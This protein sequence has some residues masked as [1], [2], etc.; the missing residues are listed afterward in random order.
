MISETVFAGPQTAINSKATILNNIPLNV[1]RQKFQDPTDPIELGKVA[2]ANQNKA[3][4]NIEDAQSKGENA[5]V[6]SHSSGSSESDGTDIVKLDKLKDSPYLSSKRLVALFIGDLDER[7][8]E[9]M[10][11]DT[12][13]KYPS[14]VSVKICVDAISK[15]SLGYGY[16]NFSNDEDAGKATEE[17][18]YVPLF[19]KEV[20]IMPSLRNSF[21]RKNI[22]TNVFF[23]NLPL[24][25]LSLTTR[26]FYDT[27]K[28]Y[29]KILSCKLDR[30][31]NIGFIYFDKDTSAKS[32]IDDF[33]G[34]E[35]YGNNIM[36]GIHFDREVRKSPEFEKRKSKL[37]G[38][39]II[40]EKLLIDDEQELQEV[41][42]G[43]KAPHP[44]AIFV[45]NLPVNANEDDILDFF[46]RIGPVKS[47]F[48]SKVPK[49]NS[50]WAF[51]TYKK[52]S[53]TSEAIE[54]LNGEIFKHRKIEV[55]R[56]QKNFQHPSNNANS[57]ASD[58]DASS[59]KEYAA[60]TSDRSESFN[61][62]ANGYKLSVYL[63]NMS[64]IC[65]EEFL[66]YL[67]AQERIKT[68]KISVCLY[69]EKTLTY[70]G[71]VLCQTRNDANR[72]FEL[73]DQKLLGDSIVKASWQSKRSKMVSI[74]PNSRLDQ[75][76]V[77]SSHAYTSSVHQYQSNNLRNNKVHFSQPPV[78]RAA[79]CKSTLSAI[80]FSSNRAVFPPHKNDQKYTARRQLLQ[81]VKQQVGRCIDFLKFP[82]A[83]RDE[84]LKCITEYIFEVYWRGDVDSLTR[85]M[86]LLNTVPQNE[87]IL[88]R[89]VE[90][91][92]QFL[93]FQ[94]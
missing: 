49:Y 79:S 69:D 59:K 35:Y 26:A 55:A 72:L 31:K 74:A 25:N 93:G 85:F 6:S 14:L 65:T 28:K 32:A 51:V 17:F 50:S 5:S 21:Y 20:R 43:T 36:C 70:S 2:A 42:P 58:C 33:N 62:H 84:N 11:R 61:L 40:K 4:K 24:E 44:N 10:L 63:S 82:S 39:T 60:S 53:D 83:T 22:G 81:I 30:R 64:S 46:S 57:R 80:P 76:S 77:A 56:A 87:R 90:E 67:C 92:I 71:S 88:H 91:A 27:F 18:N 38:M 13:N 8:T 75:R 37:D 94:R 66:S 89:Q 19:G 1:Q 68:K 29:G 86:L 73:M 41:A 54:K 47:V 34:K 45:K 12:F 52:G 78:S 48:T 7:V 16:I 15:R 9:K 3:S 23:S